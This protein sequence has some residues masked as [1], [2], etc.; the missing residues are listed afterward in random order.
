M[1][2]ASQP[3][4]AAGDMAVN[5]DSFGR[6]LR[7]ENLSPRT[8]DT[9]VESCR[10]L[11][12]FLAAQGMPQDVANITREYVESFITHLLERWKPATANNRYRG[13]Q[14]F[15]R[16]LGDEGEIQTSPM[17]KMRPPRVPEEPPE[18]L[19]EPE[20]KALL[21]ACEGQEFEE[22]RDM[23]IIRVFIDTGA[24][25]AEVN[26][27]RWNPLDDE[28]ND[29]DLNLG[30]LQVL[31]KGRRPRVLPIGIPIFI[32]GEEIFDGLFEAVDVFVRNVVPTAEALVLFHEPAKFPASLRARIESADVVRPSPLGTDPPSRCPT[33]AVRLGDE[34]NHK[35]ALEHATSEQHARPRTCLLK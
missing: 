17:E 1:R 32:A 7:A 6:H 29:V 26:G 30:V 25:R 12:R 2:Q 18:V 4:T 34:L 23:A 13:L 22:R 14:S 16:W 31:G 9:Y 11:A 20:L 19:R 21:K 27:L 24:R 35:E 33:L 10:Q 3:I 15:F 5:I 8:I 28:E